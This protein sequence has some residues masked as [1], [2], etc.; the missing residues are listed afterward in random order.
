MKT[1]RLEWILGDGDSTTVGVC[2]E[3]GHHQ[4]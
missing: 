3:L 1:S 4:S 2:G